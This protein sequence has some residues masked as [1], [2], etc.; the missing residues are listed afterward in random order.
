MNNRTNEETKQIQD[1][2]KDLIAKYTPTGKQVWKA[3][4]IKKIVQKYKKYQLF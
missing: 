4:I 3:L 1:I 2:E